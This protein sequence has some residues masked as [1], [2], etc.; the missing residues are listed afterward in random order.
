[1][2]EIAIPKE[3][4]P[5][6]DREIEAVGILIDTGGLTYRAA[7]C[8]PNSHECMDMFR[9][10]P[11]ETWESFDRGCN[12]CVTKVDDCDGC[13]MRVWKASSGKGSVAINSLCAGRIS[14]SLYVGRESEFTLQDIWFLVWYK[15]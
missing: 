14:I 1:M 2:P 4:R 5:D 8:L 13:E 7:A 15:Q 10:Y 6:C 12:E 11:V 9:W 3:S